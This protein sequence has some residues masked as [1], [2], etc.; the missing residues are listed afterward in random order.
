[1][2]ENKKEENIYEKMASYLNECPE[3]IDEGTFRSEEE[4]EEFHKL[5]F[6]WDEC[7]PSEVETEEIWNKTLLKIKQNDAPGVVPLRRR[8]GIICVWIGSVAAVA[9]LLVRSYFFFSQGGTEK[10]GNEGEKMEQYMLA[11]SAD[12]EAKEVTLV[13]SDKKKIELANNSQIAYSATG[14]VRIN[15]DRL[16]E[17]EKKE[18]EAKEKKQAQAEEYNQIIVPKG[19]R[20]MIMLA[21]NSKIWINSGSKVI[22]PRAF[23]GEKREIFIEG[24]VYL[25]VARNEEKPF[26]VNTSGF[27]VEVLGTSFNISAYKGNSKAN[28]VLVEGAVNVKDKQ[29]RHIKMQPNELVV[30]TEEGIHGKEKVNALEYINWVDG[31]WAL[32]GKTLKEVL[33]YLTEYYGQNVFCDPSIENELFYGKLFLNEDLNKVLESIRQTLPETLAMKDN[34]IYAESY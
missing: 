29:Q 7:H 4:K 19:R 3:S 21:D 30:L 28:V 2:E 14:Q 27:E 17:D 32:N 18:N 34:I 33:Q 24:E 31:V 26:V 9:V 22:Y 25:Q 6:L 10:E 12:E 15:T 5:K 1:M 11:N 16:Q 8:Q 13:M 20:S 23:K